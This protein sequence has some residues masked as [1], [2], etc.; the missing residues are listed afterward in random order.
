VVSCFRFSQL[1]PLGQADQSLHTAQ[2]RERMTASFDLSADIE[3]ISCTTSPD[4][5]VNFSIKHSSTLFTEAQMN[6][7]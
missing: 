1:K 4:E 3:A 6:P 2:H 5:R 7:E